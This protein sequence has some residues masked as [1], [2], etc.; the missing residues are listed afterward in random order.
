LRRQKKKKNEKGARSDSVP[1]GGGGD[2][3][4]ASRKKGEKGGVRTFLVEK[5]EGWFSPKKRKNFD[6]ESRP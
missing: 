1:R 6:P 5:K 3:G 4:L 2:S